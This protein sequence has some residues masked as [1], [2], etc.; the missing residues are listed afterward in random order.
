M[1]KNWLSAD[2]RPQP[3]GPGQPSHLHISGQPGGPD[4]MVQRPHL[5]AGKVCGGGMEG[6]TGEEG[7]WGDGWC[8]GDRLPG[9]WSRSAPCGGDGAPGRRT[10]GLQLF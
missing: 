4:V 9:C 3:P 5:R 6:N 7:C 8:A 2:P 10:P 1:K